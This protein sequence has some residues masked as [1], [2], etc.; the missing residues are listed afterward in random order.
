M[1]QSQVLRDIVQ[2]KKVFTWPIYFVD[3][4]KIMYIFKHSSAIEML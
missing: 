1:V 2:G 3:D 4:L